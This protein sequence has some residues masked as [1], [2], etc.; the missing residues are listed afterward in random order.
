MAIVLLI[1]MGFEVVVLVQVLDCGWMEL[2]DFCASS[3]RA[4]EGGRW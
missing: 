4:E 3:G 2:E 1:V